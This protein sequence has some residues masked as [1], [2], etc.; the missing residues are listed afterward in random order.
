MGITLKSLDSPEL[1]ITYGKN[2][3]DF[4]ITCTECDERSL[5]GDQPATTPP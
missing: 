1:K 2:A 3:L 4:F 5:H